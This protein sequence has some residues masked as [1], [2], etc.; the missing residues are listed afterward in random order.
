MLLIDKTAIANLAVGY[1]G[2]SL[3]I[4]D[5]DTDNSSQAKIVRRH[6]DLALKTM[7]ERHAWRFATSYAAL[8]LISTDPMSGYGY[9]YSIPADALTIRQIAQKDSFIRTEIYED[10]K[11]D[12]EEILTGTGITIHT[13]IEEAYV[14][15]TRSL[16]PNSGF[17][18]YFGRGLAALLSQ[19]IAPSLITNNFAKVKRALNEDSERRINEAIA[20]DLGRQPRRK[21]PVSPFISARN[22]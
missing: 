8:A 12:F 9:V 18:Q 6:F 3:S 10:E 7:L 13:N 22:S 1:L 11:H 19:E 17:P 2:S 16:D 4:T 21:D 20:T 5:L 15:Y 14:E